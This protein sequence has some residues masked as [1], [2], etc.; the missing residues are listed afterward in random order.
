MPADMTSQRLPAVTQQPVQHSNPSEP[1]RPNETR[2]YA[3]TNRQPLQRNSPIV[4]VTNQASFSS[5]HSRESADQQIEGTT[6]KRR[7]SI[8]DY[9]PTIGGPVS[10]RR[11]TIH[12]HSNSQNKSETPF[13]NVIGNHTPPESSEFLPAINFDDFHNSISSR[14]PSLSHFPMPGQLVAG[15][16]SAP[17]PPKSTTRWSTTA[18]S[19]SGPKPARPNTLNRRQSNAQKPD[20]EGVGTDDKAMLHL[21]SLPLLALGNLGNLLDLVLRLRLKQTVMMALLEGVRALQREMQRGKYG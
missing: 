7:K 19:A 16:G 21:Q 18:S 14:E 11:T 2:F 17:S 10:S 3:Q 12:S 13:P 6:S 8:R 1:P 9:S 4:P 15:I 20:L 5:F